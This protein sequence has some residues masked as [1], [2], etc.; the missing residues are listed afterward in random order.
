MRPL[1]D[2]VAQAEDARDPPPFDIPEGRLQGREVAMDVR[3]QGNVIHG[4]DPSYVTVL[5]RQARRIH[6]PCSD[7]VTRDALVRRWR[8]SVRTMR[9]HAVCPHDALFY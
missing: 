7:L 1:A 9:S 3:D 5:G 2:E 6:R 4:V 8:I